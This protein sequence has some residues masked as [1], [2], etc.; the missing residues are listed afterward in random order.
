[1]KPIRS[2][3]HALTLA[4]LAAVG[5]LTLTACNDDAASSDTATTPPATGAPATK[6]ARILTTL[7]HRMRR[8]GARR[9]LATMCVG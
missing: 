7:L 6:A 3:R 1:M 4:S 2:S 8:T 9:G 5:A